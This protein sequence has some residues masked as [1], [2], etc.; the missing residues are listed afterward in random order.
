P[1]KM[2]QEYR[3][4]LKEI[5]LYARTPT[6]GWTLQE[7]GGPDLTRFA[8]KAPLDGEYW[9]TLVTVDRTGRMAPSDLNAEPVSQRVVIDTTPPVIQVQPTAIPDGDYALRCT[10]LDANPDMATLRAVCRTETGDIPLDM[11]VGQPGVFRVRGA[12]M[13][14]HPLFVMVRD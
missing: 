8:C 9:Y 6:S 2:D 14:R 1:V 3:R 4:E 12:E 7:T 13:M 11:V 5:R 10:V